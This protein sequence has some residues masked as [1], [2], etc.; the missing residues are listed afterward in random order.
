MK[1]SKDLQRLKVL[2]EE[3]TQSTDEFYRLADATLSGLVKSKGDKNDDDDGYT[4]DDLGDVCGMRTMFPSNDLVSGSNGSEFEQNV[5][6]LSVDYDPGA[7][8]NV[9]LITEVGEFDLEDFRRDDVIDLIEYM[10]SYRKG[11]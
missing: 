1:H 8:S 5:R 7:D 3:A 6:Y 2:D 10:E 11:K 9:L 4:F